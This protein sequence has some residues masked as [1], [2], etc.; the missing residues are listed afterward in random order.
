MK[1]IFCL[2]FLLLNFIFISP[3]SAY[4]YSAPKTKIAGTMKTRYSH[5]IDS[6]APIIEVKGLPSRDSRIK[7]HTYKEYENAS[8]KVIV[9][10]P[11]EVSNSK[12]PGS[13]E[14]SLVFKSVDKKA[15]NIKI[16]KWQFKTGIGAKIDAVVRHALEKD[17]GEMRIK[18]ILN[19]EITNRYKYDE[20][21]NFYF[22]VR[23]KEKKI[24]IEFTIEMM[25]PEG[26]LVE[27]LKDKIPL[28]RGDYVLQS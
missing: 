6:D 15:M 1:I 18:D 8:Y 11:V 9:T 25:G 14:A 27:V 22:D 4:P 21:F 24:S 5:F 3:E 20:E 17:R 7:R 28:K 19:R 10:Y 16:T 2:L 23:S 26:E 12:K 13:Y